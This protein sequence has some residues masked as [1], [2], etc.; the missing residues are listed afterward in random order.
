MDARRAILRDAERGQPDRTMAWAHSL[1][2]AAS[3]INY[4][5]SNLPSGSATPTAADG[6]AYDTNVTPAT[7]S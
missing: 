6:I 3:V 5:A 1:P 2:I 7:C 4:N